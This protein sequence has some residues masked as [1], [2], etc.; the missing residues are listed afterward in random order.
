MQYHQK[1]PL[2]ALAGGLTGAVLRAMQLSA[3]FE[4]G[5]GLYMRGSLWGR[6]LVFWLVLLAA[7]F[8][9]AARRGQHHASFEALFAGSGDLYKTLVAFSGM[10]LAAGGALWLVVEFPVMQTVQEESGQWVMALELPFGILCIASGLSIIGLGAVLTRG[11]LT[12]RH[13]LLTLPPLFWASFHL[14]VSYRQYCVS[15]NLALFTLEI[16]ASVACVMSYYHLARMLYGTPAPRRFA[17]WAAGAVALTLSDVLGYA[18]SR[19]L[20]AS[21]IRW[22]AS[23]VIRGCCLLF[24]CCFLLI[25]LSLMASR[26]F[27]PLPETEATAQEPPAPSPD[28]S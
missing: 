8:A 7:A 17:F 3:A 18:L 22:D 28:D 2:M 11:T 6:L 23:S 4:P 15:A 5:T 20:G 26:T 1:L 9:A 13:A 21:V 14:L 16:F 12:A 10:L 27:P 19:V 25:E 24:G